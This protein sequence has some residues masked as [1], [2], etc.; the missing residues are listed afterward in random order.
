MRH[1]SDWIGEQA[2]KADVRDSEWVAAGILVIAEGN[3]QF[4][5]PWKGKQDFFQQATGG[6]LRQLSDGGTGRIHHGRDGERLDRPARVPRPLGRSFVNVKS[7]ES[8][9]LFDL[10]LL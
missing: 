4:Q 3:Q 5:T 9:H 2:T 10:W 7:V 6:E 1:G 8:N